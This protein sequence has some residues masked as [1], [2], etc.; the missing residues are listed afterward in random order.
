MKDKIMNHRYAIPITVDGTVGIFEG[1]NLIEKVNTI[2]GK[3]NIKSKGIRKL[4]VPKGVT[5][6]DCS[7]N[8]LTNLHFHEGIKIIDC[9][10]NHL[11]SIHLPKGVT[12]INCSYNNLTELNLPEGIEI[13]VCHDNY[14]DELDVPKSTK[15]VNCSYNDLTKL[16]LSEGIRVVYCLD[17]QLTELDLPEGVKVVNCPNNQLQGVIYIPA[18]VNR[19][20]LINNPIEVVV[21]TIEQDIPKI[22]VDPGVPIEIAE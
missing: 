16:N 13:V 9:Y 11:S 3:L 14:I 19:I 12:Q 22:I 10:R 17:N 8:D 4:I 1:D 5:Q 6:V 18:R 2:D 21:V 15:L 20:D 7:Y